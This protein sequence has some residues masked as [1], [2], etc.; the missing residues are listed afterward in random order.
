MRPLLVGGLAA[1]VSAIFLFAVPSVPA[2]ADDPAAALLAKH[3]SFVGWQF[4]DGSIRTLRLTGQMLK[5]SDGSLYSATKEL[6]VG[7]IDRIDTTRKRGTTYE[8]F[9]GRVFWNSD[10][11][12]FTRAS[13]GDPAKYRASLNALFDEG[14]QE[15]TGTMRPSE[16]ISGQSLSVVRV[17]VPNAFPIDLYVDPQSGEYKRAVLDPSGDQEQ[18]LNILAYADVVPGKKVIS[19]WKYLGSEYTHEYTK[20]V[21]NAE[22]T[23]D[24]LHPPPQ[25][26]SWT[27]AN[28]QPFPIK[29]TEHR[30]IIDAKVNGVAGKF[31]LDSGSSS[32]FLTNAFAEKAHVKALDKSTAQGIAGSLKINLDRADTV[33]VGGNTLHN[34]R[35]SSGRGAMDSDAPD[36]LI[37]FDFL[38]GAVVTVDFNNQ[39]MTIADPTKTRVDA[40]AGVP[41]V[42]DLTNGTPVVE[43]KL[44]GGVSVNATLDSG[45]AF[46]V[47]YPASMVQ[48]YDI[49]MMIDDTQLGSRMAISGVSGNYEV[50]LCGHLETLTLGPIVYQAPPACQ[51]PSFSG[52]D[53]LVGF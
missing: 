48:K 42:A 13:F 14:T 10:D 44:N 52:R 28:S 5:D 8:G 53:V 16:T 23:N 2:R 21:G 39:Q 43:M 26:A 35:L 12:G 36:G 49:R 37:G 6:R 20:I 30:I 3:K 46:Y 33:E 32:I 29:V 22:I 18:T 27:F 9:T 31:T 51:S 34:V 1:F 25:T 50:G 24:E 41:V 40:G 47:L 38:A 17:D 7:L 15:L 19:K 45:N 4:G 11:N